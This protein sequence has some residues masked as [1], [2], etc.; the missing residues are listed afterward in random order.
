M[1]EYFALGLNIQDG[2]YC[3]LSRNS[4]YHKNKFRLSHHLRIDCFIF[5]WHGQGCAFYQKNEEIFTGRGCYYIISE[6]M[7]LSSNGIDMVVP[8]TK[9]TVAS[10]I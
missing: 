9:S 7:V 10:L 5:R 6:L 4:E 3:C 2:F 1:K 8:L